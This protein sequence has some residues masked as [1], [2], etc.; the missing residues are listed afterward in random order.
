MSHSLTNKVYFI[1]G[2]T[3]GIGRAMALRLAQEGACVAITGKTTREEQTD[4]GGSIHSVAQ[5][6]KDLGGQALPLEL[7]VRHDQAISEAIGL[8]AQH[9]ERIDGV[10]CNAGALD[11]SPAL[12]TPMKRF[13]LLQQVNVRATFATIQA[14]IPHLQKQDNAHIMV[15]APPINLNRQWFRQGLAYTISK[16]GMSLCV[17]GFAEELADT[18]IAVN[19]LW[20]STLIATAAVKH[21]FPKLYPLSRQ[22][23]IVAD[24]AYYLLK[25]END[26]YRGEFL[27][28][29]QILQAQGVTDFD[30]YAIDAS[31]SP[32]PDFYI[33]HPEA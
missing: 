11:L 20:P 13:D 30:Q 24:A 22:P 29:E 19:G 33:D 5:E 21:H 9:W 17:K 10:I 18:T 32:Y 6:V 2:A 14:A 8:T 4:H 28:D 16:Y 23:S 3:R 12:Q 31:Q 25:Q 27:T 7:D 1:T 15:M 26:R